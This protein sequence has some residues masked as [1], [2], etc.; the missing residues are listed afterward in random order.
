MK[1]VSLSE[2]NEGDQIAEPVINN[3]GQTL[4]PANTV[5]TV[6]YIN[7]LR[8]WGIDKVFVFDESASS[9]DKI[10]LSD[11]TRRYIDQQ[12]SRR[13]QW[14]P[15]NEWES[16]IFHLASSRMVKNLGGKTL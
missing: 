4:I 3:F 13:F 14:K 10:E 1:K 11:E 8:M 12:L 7:L 2:L 16:A 6:R 15:E 9:N 5:I